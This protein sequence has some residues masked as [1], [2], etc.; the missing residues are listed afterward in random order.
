MQNSIPKKK[1][2][3]D[4]G[5]ALMKSNMNKMHKTSSGKQEVE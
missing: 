3:N 1:K 4:N 5:A 2:N